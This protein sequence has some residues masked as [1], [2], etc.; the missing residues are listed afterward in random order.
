LKKKNNIKVEHSIHDNI[1]LNKK[2]GQY[3]SIIDRI[4]K[5]ESSIDTKMVT[6]KT[7]LIIDQ[8]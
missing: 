6:I 5:K 3:Y 2:H 8:S 1:K 4:Y 7:Y